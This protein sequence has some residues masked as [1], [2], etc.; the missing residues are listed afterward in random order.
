VRI[1]PVPGTEFGVAYAS[2]PPVVS[3]LA[4]GSLVAGIG[5]ILV[6]LVVTCFGLV[7]A[8][9]GWGAWTAGA[10]ALLALLASAVAIM[11]GVLARRQIAAPAPASAV[12][13]SGRGIVVAG[14]SCG[15]VGLA[16]TVLA[17]GAALALQL[18]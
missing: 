6:A 17:F 7:G 3:G 15:G 4:V 1:E 8:R 2:V 13:Y 9:D 12:R 18:G 5:S 10:F 11:L 16:G 14:V